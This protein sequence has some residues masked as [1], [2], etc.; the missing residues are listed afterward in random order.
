MGGLE[1]D[2]N[3]ADVFVHADMFWVICE[4]LFCFF[5]TGEIVVRFAA[6][7]RKRDCLKDS[8]F[9]FDAFLVVLM[10]GE[11]WGMMLA[12]VFEAELSGLPTAPLR[13]L[14][15]LRLSRW[16]RLLRSFPEL[17]TML[18]G[19]KT[20][21]RAVASCLL[22]VL[23]LVYVFAIVMLITCSGLSKGTDEVH[24][25]I[26]NSL[27][28]L[29]RCMWTLLMDGTFM[30]DAATILTALRD[31]HDFDGYLAVLFFLAFMMLSALTALNMLIGVL[32]D[33]VTNVGQQLRDDADIAL[34]KIGIL[35]ELQQFDGNGDG[36]ITQ[37]ELEHVMRSEQAQAVLDDLEID[38]AAL[39]Q[40]HGMLFQCPT[41]PVPILTIVENCLNYRGSQ[42][43]TVKHLIDGMVFNRHYMERS[44]NVAMDDIKYTLIRQ[45]Q[46]VMKALDRQELHEAFIATHWNSLASEWE[47]SL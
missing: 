15:L 16:V 4:N 45:N 26:R 12:F 29:S 43:A 19:F 34:V 23:F 41:D 30:L 31:A 40:L 21:S 20:A 36:T 39:E 38:A 32:C 1:A 6:Y 47:S 18:E 5:F 13:L 14:R 46:A 3:P 17:V 35:K 28:T 2:L 7:E 10:I 8:W 37:L 42:A 27:G 44:V 25:T 33:V 11:V 24:T 22:V 9:L